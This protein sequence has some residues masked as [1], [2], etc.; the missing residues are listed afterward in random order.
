MQKRA[1]GSLEGLD[2]IDPIGSDPY[3]NRRAVHVVLEEKGS[4]T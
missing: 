2:T 1:R 4:K 3:R